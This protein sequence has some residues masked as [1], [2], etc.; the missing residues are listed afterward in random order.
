VVSIVITGASSG[1][2]AAAAVALSRDG[3]RVLATGRSTTRLARVHAEQKAAVPHGVAVPDPVAC[4]L[5]TFDGV[6]GLARTVAEALPDVSVLVNNC[7]VQPRTRRVTRDGLEETFAV[8]HVAP[9]FLTGL[10]AARLRTNGGRVVTTGSSSHLEAGL[11]LDD[12]QLE[13]GWTAE[14]A[15]GRSKLY[16]ML[17]TL[18]GRERLGLPMSTFH[19]GVIRTAINRDARLVWLTKPFEYLFMAPPTKGA[20][21]MQ[22]LATAPEG[23]A[24]RHLY[25]I[26]RAPAETSTAAADATAARRLWKLTEE[27][28]P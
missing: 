15:Y 26:D 2:G 14:E 7:A 19:P 20:D 13:S 17:F 4:D 18:E 11:H 16:N 21:T 10:L 24:P 3:H 1:I 27:L 5:E 12:P 8:N 23:A 6:R 9:F 28:L 22:W 25:Y